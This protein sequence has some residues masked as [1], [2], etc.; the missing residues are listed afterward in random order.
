MTEETGSPGIAIVGIAC[1]FPGARDH[2]AFWQNLCNG[3]ESITALSDDE[4]TAAGVSAELLR[5]PAYVKCAPL[6]PD[7]EMFDA[8]FF[9]YSPQEARLNFMGGLGCALFSRY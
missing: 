6:L 1:R 9:E 4:L 8:G 7:I 5:D 3:V 2:R